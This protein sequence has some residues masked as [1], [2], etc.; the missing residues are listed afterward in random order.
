MKKTHNKENKTCCRNPYERVVVTGGG[1]AATIKKIEKIKQKPE[2]LLK[3]IVED[4][5][6]SSHNRW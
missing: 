1:E 4:F 6:P 3:R 5:T 2:G